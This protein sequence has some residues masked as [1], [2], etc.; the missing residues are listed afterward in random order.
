MHSHGGIPHRV[1]VLVKQ[2]IEQHEATFLA[3]C[4]VVR[5]SDAYYARDVHAVQACRP[6][7]SIAA[8][9]RHTFQICVSVWERDVCDVFILSCGLQEITG[10]GMEIFERNT[11]NPIRAL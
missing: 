3:A 9:S 7:A 8:S 10:V 5:A 11:T 1:C 2:V 6:V 4:D